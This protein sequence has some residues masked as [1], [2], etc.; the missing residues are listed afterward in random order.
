METVIACQLGMERS[1]EQPALAR[2]NDCSPIKCRER[3]YILAHRVDAR[4]TNEHCGKRRW[5]ECRDV[6]I[7][8]ETVKLASKGVAPGR[9]IHQAEARLSFRTPFGDS[10]RE[11][12][13]PGAS[14]P[15]GHLA[16][17]PLLYRF[18]KAIR[19]EQFADRRAL[20]TWNNQAVDT[21]KVFCKPHL[22]NLVPKVADNTLVLDKCPLQGKYTYV[23]T[24]AGYR[25]WLPATG[26]QQFPL[27]NLADLDTNHC[28]A[29]A[30]AYF[31]D[32]LRVPEMC[33]RGDDRLRALGRITG[34]EDA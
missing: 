7:R 9:D 12:D 13:H 23:H 32:D 4:R 15:D 30:L 2:R 24:I 17:S 21:I 6:E 34:F 19:H 26:R 16:P 10:I 25:C 29:Q 20:T 33:R 8:F 18:H 1:R 27:R 5:P 11:Q 22:G 3:L 28:F 14:A 31:G